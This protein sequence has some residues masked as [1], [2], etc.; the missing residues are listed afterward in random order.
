MRKLL[1][2]STVCLFMVGLIAIG[3][4]TGA[5]AKDIKVGAV[6]NLTGPASQ[7]NRLDGGRP[8]LQGPRSPQIC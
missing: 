5:C 6:I 3:I 2:L 4:P 1:V 7:Q 8:R